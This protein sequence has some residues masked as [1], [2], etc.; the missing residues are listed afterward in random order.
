M[1]LSLKYQ[2]D[3]TIL[4]YPPP[5]PASIYF[6]SLSLSLSIRLSVWVYNRGYLN[7]RAL[8]PEDFLT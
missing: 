1:S 6:Q 7:S 5:V 3:G 4:Y 8:F 2:H